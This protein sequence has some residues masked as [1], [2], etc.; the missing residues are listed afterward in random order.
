MTH[1]AHVK[2]AESGG[3][4]DRTVVQLRQAFRAEGVMMIVLS[5]SEGS[6]FAAAM[7]DDLKHYLPTLFRNI[8]REVEQALTAERAA[9][10]CP[11][12]SS[13]LALDPNQ[14]LP[15]DFRP[16][17]GSLCVCASCASFLTLEDAW[18]VITEAELRELPDE[19]RIAMT[20][21]RRRVEGRP[22]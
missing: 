19:V 10:F 3:T 16:P 9:M 15:Q 8:A 5:G 22:Q 7:P 18:R 1:D 12:C 6:S 14:N 4:Y 2:I 13:P 17:E 20:R 21:T 11:V